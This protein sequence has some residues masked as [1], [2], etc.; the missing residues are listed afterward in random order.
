MLGQGF[1][2]PAAVRTSWARGRQHV[3]SKAWAMGLFL[4]LMVAIGQNAEAVSPAG[5]V[6]KGT[7]HPTG[8]V[9]AWDAIWDRG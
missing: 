2:N 8:V 9:R 6:T 1:W 3:G 5:I 7:N 4:L